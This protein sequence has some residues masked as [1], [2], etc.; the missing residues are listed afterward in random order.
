MMNANQTFCGDHF[1]I[2]LSQIIILYTLNL[3]SA[4]C[5]LYINKLR[6]N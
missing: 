1:T 4:A 3:H 5:Q 2:Y 6:E